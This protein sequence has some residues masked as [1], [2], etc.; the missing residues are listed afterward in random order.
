M[1]DSS[2]LPY[3]LIFDMDGVIIDNTASQARAFQLLFRDLGLSTNARRLL[4]RLNGMPAGEILKTVF[5]KPV[6]EKKIEEYAAQRELLYRVLYWN[7]RQEVAGLRGFLQAA[8]AAGFKTALGTG[9]GDDT[10][11]YILDYLDLRQYFDVVIG[12]DDVRQ[13]KPH[14]DTYTTTARKLGL[15]PGQCVVFEDALL[16]EQAAY[17]AGMR[18]I[19]LSTTL[20]PTDFQAPLAVIPDFT[21][22]TPQHVRELLAQHPHAPKPSKELAKRQYMQG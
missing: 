19:A 4:R 5:T 22:L 7:K 1:P 16:G 6:P 14:A 13:G 8:R 20:Q 9:S 12:K 18:C 11:S 15:P 3:A 10:I 21:H 17:R 2:P